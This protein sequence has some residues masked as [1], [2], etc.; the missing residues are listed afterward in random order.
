MRERKAY[1]VKHAVWIPRIRYLY[2]LCRARL[3]NPRVYV[4]RK[5]SFAKGKKQRGIWHRVTPLFAVKSSSN[6]LK[7]RVYIWEI[8]ALSLAR[9]FLASPTIV[10][11]VDPFERIYNSIP[12]HS[13]RRLSYK[14][15]FLL[16]MKIH[17]ICLYIRLYI[18]IVNVS[19]QQSMIMTMLLDAQIQLIKVLFY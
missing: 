4:L 1:F 15:F 5:G 14:L 16:Q 18:G 17:F 19:M 10:V 7:V 6:F 8:R 12:F 13:P 11:S 3:W 9:Y 2:V